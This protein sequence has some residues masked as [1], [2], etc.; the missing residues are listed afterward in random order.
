M[1]DKSFIVL[2]NTKA[3][4]NKGDFTAMDGVS[5]YRERAEI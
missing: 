4:S 2:V 1:L 5:Q 3:S